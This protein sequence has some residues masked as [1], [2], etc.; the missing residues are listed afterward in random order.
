[1]DHT[2]FAEG[3]GAQLFFDFVVFGLTFR[4]SL[5]LRRS[6]THSITN[7]MY[8]DGTSILLSSSPHLTCDSGSLYFACVE[9][10]IY[11]YPWLLMLSG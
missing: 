9:V 4:A 11:V 1:M 8:R 6:V 7:V 10:C 3:C 2:D 5:R